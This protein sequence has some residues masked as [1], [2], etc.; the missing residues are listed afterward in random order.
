MP[1]GFV[2]DGVEEDSFVDNNGDLGH[3]DRNDEFL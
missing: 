1:F 2:D 3:L